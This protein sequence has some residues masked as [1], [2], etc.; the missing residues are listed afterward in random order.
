MSGSNNPQAALQ[1]DNKT[2]KKFYSSQVLELIFDP[3]SLVNYV[4]LGVLHA[5]AP[6]PSL[7]HFSSSIFLSND[8]ADFS[9]NETVTNVYGLHKQLTSSGFLSVSDYELVAEVVLIEKFGKW[10]KHLDISKTQKIGYKFSWFRN[11]SGVYV[12]LFVPEKFI[13]NSLHDFQFDKR[14][15]PLKYISSVLNIFLFQDLKILTPY[16]KFD[17]HDQQVVAERDKIQKFYSEVAESKKDPWP[18]YKLRTEKLSCNLLPYQKDAIRWMIQRELETRVVMPQFSFTIEVET[19]IGTVFYLPSLGVITKNAD[20][21]HNFFQCTGGILADVMGLGKTVEVIG[22]ITNFT[23]DNVPELSTDD[24]INETWIGY[25]SPS[26]ERKLTWKK[27]QREDS[28]FEL[29]DKFCSKTKKNG[30][31]K[32]KGVECSMCWLVFDPEDV[33]WNKKRGEDFTCP[34]CVQKKLRIDSAATLIIVPFALIQQWCEELT[35]HSKNTLKIL[36]YYGVRNDQYVHPQTFS[37]YDVI[38][39]TFETLI[40]ELLFVNLGEKKLRK[41]SIYR[42]P[43]SPLKCVHFWRVCVDESQLVSWKGGKLGEMCSHISARA[44]WHISGTPLNDFMDELY[45]FV[46]TLGIQPF[47]SESVFKKCLKMWDVYSGGVGEL[48]SQPL[49]QLFRQIMWRNTKDS[50]KEQLSLPPVEEKTINITLS[51]F[52]ERVYKKMTK[53]MKNKLA[54]IINQTCKTHELVYKDDQWFRHCR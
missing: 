31:Q 27:K 26:E 54:P 19:E 36:L 16:Q 41:R 51:Q 42:Y 2:N 34:F 45:G 4:A 37:E 10:L 38:L 48:R 6:S 11:N 46:K 3:S 47:T 24:D 9:S 53:L 17:Y 52:D 33:C 8:H 39:T 32:G 30:L 28:R 13:I 40:G 23:K 21:I 44:W 7:Y 20:G 29:N 15:S 1:V 18:N 35:K 49:Y 50:V 5:C 22:L 14:A 12:K 25:E 43:E